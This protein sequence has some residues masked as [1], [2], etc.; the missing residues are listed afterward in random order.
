MFSKTLSAVINND[1]LDISYDEDLF[2][3][4]DD[5]LIEDK[6]ED[7]QSSSDTKFSTA[8]NVIQSPRAYKKEYP[9][10]NDDLAQSLLKY[11]FET[12]N[13]SDQSKQQKQDQSQTPKVPQRLKNLAS[14]VLFK[15]SVVN[16]NVVFAKVET[17]LKEMKPDV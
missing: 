1:K 2:T 9:K 8:Q 4:G 17:H 10:L 15:L 3:I 14:R 12:L 16:F 7:E 6:I 11:I 13:P 5:E